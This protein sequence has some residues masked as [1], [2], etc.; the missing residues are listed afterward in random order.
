M[1]RI[2]GA[3]L[4]LCVALTG[5]ATA[6]ASK[7]PTARPATTTAMPL[8]AYGL[9]PIQDRSVQLARKR[10]LTACLRERGIRTD[11]PDPRPIPF[12][13]NARRYGVTEESRAATAGYSAPEISE[14]AES[15]TLPK[16]TQKALRGAHGCQTEATRTLDAGTSTPKPDL[17]IAAELGAVTL[18]RSTHDSRVRAVFAKWSACMTKAGYHYSNPQDA[19]G[20]PAFT[21]G[22]GHRVTRTETATAVADVRCKKATDLV[23]VWTGVEIA[24]QRLAIAQNRPRLTAARAFLGIR[25]R[26]AAARDVLLRQ[27][28]SPSH[29]LI[30]VTGRVKVL[31]V[32]A[33]GSVLV[34]AVRGPG[35]ILGDMSV[36]DGAGRSATV[37]AVDA[38]ETRVIL[39]ERFLL[40][41]RSLGLEAQLLRHA[42]GRIREGEA[43]R[44]EQAALPAGP[45]IVRTLLRLTTPG[46][47]EQ[48]DIGLDQ[49]ELGLAAGGLARSTVAAELAHLRDQGLIATRRRRIVITDLP[50]LRALAESG[51]GNV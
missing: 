50:G 42:M 40:L 25:L 44:A 22:L 29:V 18:G 20:D 14:R 1:R 43:W 9:T 41:V 46:P 16:K 8:D 36:L 13:R 5:C 7:E 48:I 15:P 35:E 3:T 21:D 30:L 11:L 10:L 31:R 6:G 28:D 4:V 32:S 12:A 19:I 26:N 45:R 39:A 17:S 27:G 24:Y 38:C 2:A 49:T 23:P 33:E 51:H 47:A 34:L 37:V